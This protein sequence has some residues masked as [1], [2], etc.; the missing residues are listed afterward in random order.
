[1]AF[2]GALLRFV[3]RRPGSLGK[4]H[5]RDNPT[6]NLLFERRSVRSFKDEDISDEHMS[7]ILEAGSYAPSSVNLQ[8]WSFIS[9][10]R[11]SWE[12]KFETPIPF[13]APRA[14]LVCGDTHRLRLTFPDLPDA[15]LLAHTV[16]VLN[17]SIAAMNMTIAAEALGFG[18]CMLSE[19]G[20]SGFFDLDHL[21]ERLE[22]PEGVFPILTLVLGRPT[23]RS[24][25]IP[26]RLPLDA[27]V[28][29]GRYPSPKEETLGRWVE[30][31][32]AGVR[33]S[34]G[35]DIRSALEYYAKRFDDVEIQLRKH[36]LGTKE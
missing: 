18:S 32:S 33:V 5:V 12:G 21:K 23:L 36:V 15:P 3:F 31:M 34:G 27:I 2:L 35:G 16:G 7:V 30:E 9:F 11:K 24:P 20:R 19:T 14:I 25:V 28:G 8:P 26:P 6:L 10:T 22:L 29:E 13:G 4:A 1:M 17:A